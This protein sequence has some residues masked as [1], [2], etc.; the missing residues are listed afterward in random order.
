MPLR[1]A[2]WT[3]ARLG[4]QGIAIDARHALRPEELSQTGLRQLKKLLGDLN[5]RVCSVEFRTRRGYNVA[6]ALERRI[7]ATK[8]AMRMAFQ[9]GTPVV[10][11]HVGAIPD[12]PTGPEWDLLI[13]SLTDL[14]RYGQH[15]GSQLAAET[16]TDDGTRLAALIDALPDGSL[17]AE[18]DPGAL[19]VQGF[20]PRAALE[21]L[22][23]HV[24]Q[25]RATDGVRGL[26]RSRGIE[27]PLGRGSADYV[28]LIGMLEEREYRGYFTLARE[29]A[30]DPV[31]EIGNGV[32]Y[33][34]SLFM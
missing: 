22:V 8:R 3:A 1:E 33:L 20:D 15:V 2:L 4:A 11:N 23:A 27:T 19:I 18:F 28:E 29:N 21:R 10:V 5:L 25:I 13:Q 6:E 16:G 9:L 31:S 32:Q 24:V 26:G 7:E 34:R 30:S 17:A 14:G 12:E